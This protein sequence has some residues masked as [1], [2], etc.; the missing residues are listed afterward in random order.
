MAGDFNND[1][2]DDF[3]TYAGSSSS[4]AYPLPDRPGALPYQYKPILNLSGMGLTDLSWVATLTNLRRLDVSNNSLTARNIEQINTLELEE[5][6]A[7]NNLI[8]SAEPFYPMN[9]TLRSL[10]LKNNLIQKFDVFQDVN[11]GNVGGS[12]IFIDFL[13]LS[14][15]P[16]YDY[17][18]YGNPVLY[19]KIRN[20][21]APNGSFF[22]DKSNPLASGFDLSNEN[23]LGLNRYIRYLDI[24]NTQYSNF[25]TFIA[26]NPS[27]VVVRNTDYDE[28]EHDSFD[29][30]NFGGA[31]HPYSIEQ[32][33]LTTSYS[34]S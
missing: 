28:I 19:L 21:M 24:S 26:A 6:I 8:N 5:L 20:H 12:P 3:S 27:V 11:I 2:N 14:N 7:D 22:T 23:Y 31:N 10:S 17:N 25:E 29:L 1:Y 30:G 18:S 33:D 32:C 34:D 15:N 9:D 16:L 13:D 4:G